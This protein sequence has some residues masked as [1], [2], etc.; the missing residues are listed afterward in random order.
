MAAAI[1]LDVLRCREPSHDR[2]VGVTKGGTAHL[3]FVSG[4]KNLVA[5]QPSW[6]FARHWGTN[7]RPPNESSTFVYPPR[8]M[9][10]TF[11]WRCVKVTGRYPLGRIAPILPPGWENEMSHHL[12]PAIIKRLRRADGHLRTIIEMI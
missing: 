9:G 8:R 5:R 12:H 3:L 4:F 11:R 1:D 7:S 2:R 10:V 6:S